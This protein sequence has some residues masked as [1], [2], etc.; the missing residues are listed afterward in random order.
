MPLQNPIIIAAQGAILAQHAVIPTRPA[1]IPFVKARVLW[2]FSLKLCYYELYKKAPNPPVTAPNVVT[3]PTK[4]IA[5]E[6]A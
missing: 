3:T 4:P 5:F 1:K 2:S 6:P